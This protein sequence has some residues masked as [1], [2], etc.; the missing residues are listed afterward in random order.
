MRDAWGNPINPFEPFLK[1]V[2]GKCEICF[3]AGHCTI[4]QC[5]DQERNELE[6]VNRIINSSHLTAKVDEELVVSFPD[7]PDAKALPKVIKTNQKV[8]HILNKDLKAAVA[9]GTTQN[10]VPKL[11]NLVSNYFS[12]P[13][14]PIQG[15]AYQILNE[16]KTQPK[17][18]AELTYWNDN[19]GN[20]QVNSTQ[21]VVKKLNNH[22]Q[23]I[24]KLQQQA[25]KGKEGKKQNNAVRQVVKKEKKHLDR[26]VTKVNR[27]NKR[28]Q[29]KE[30]ALQ[31]IAS[32]TAVQNPDVKV[33][34]NNS[35]N[36]VK[37]YS[38]AVND[39]KKQLQQDKVNLNKKKKSKLHQP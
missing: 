21:K 23:E 1:D 38:A 31:K 5:K 33:A 25:A 18:A 12:A 2:F 35:L 32:S 30:K 16:G 15:S 14:R 27:L 6:I 4:S 39:V 7:A 24:Q 9:M 34:V 36:Q 28:L 17:S 26:L 13:Q 20:Q 29:K 8:E 37:Q 22:L 10:V 19:K 11:Q 3:R